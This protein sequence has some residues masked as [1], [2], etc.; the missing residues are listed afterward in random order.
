MTITTETPRTPD[1]WLL[2]TEKD[3]RV[4]TVGDDAALAVFSSE[5]E[6]ELFLHLAAGGG[7]RRIIRTSPRTLTPL[8]RGP[9]CSGVMRVALDPSPE[10][11]AN[12]LLVGLVSVRK[13]RFTGRDRRVSGT[14]V[15]P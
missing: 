13:E 3:G 7:G 10:M 6:A 9:S 15:T 4:L 11:L 8:L 1:F 5:G 14:P 2:V 12:D